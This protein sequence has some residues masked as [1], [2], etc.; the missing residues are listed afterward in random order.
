MQGEIPANF[1]Q[2]PTILSI[3]LWFSRPQAFA[4]SAGKKENSGTRY[5]GIAQK[6]PAGSAK[7]APGGQKFRQNA[8]TAAGQAGGGADVQENV[9][10]V[11]FFLGASSPSKRISGC[12]A[13]GARRG[14][15][16]LPATLLERSVRLLHTAERG[17][18]RL[19][20]AAQRLIAELARGAAQR[21]GLRPAWRQ[22]FR[23]CGPWRCAR[24]PDRSRARGRAPPPDCGCLRPRAWRC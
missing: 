21:V 2:I 17:G 5:A 1:L 14:A 16:V 6:I 12:L 4:F 24:S 23:C 22:A 19:L 15:A 13:A 9:R 10:S 11:G 7:R 20:R 8:T 3:R 18:N